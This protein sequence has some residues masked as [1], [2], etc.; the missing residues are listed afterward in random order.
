MPDRRTPPAVC[1][2]APMTMPREIVEHLDNG[3]TFHRF[4]GGDQ[5]ICRLTLH[6][7]GG[8]S[9]MGEA[10]AKMLISQISE[11]TTKRS[12]E[13]IAEALD[14]CGV[15]L[16]TQSQAHHSIISLSLLTSHLPGILPLLTDMI[17]A[18]AFP[19]AR[20]EVAR[21]RLISALRIAREDPAA[22]ADIKLQ[23]L[24]WGTENPLA[25]EMTEADIDAVDTD[26][27]HKC[28]IR[29]I[30]PARM[31]AYLSGLLD[32]D[33]VAA[34]RDFLNNIPVLSD[35][36]DAIYYPPK[37]LPG[38]TMVCT[39][40]TNTMQT[41]ISCALPAPGREHP[42]YVPLRLSVMALG[43][44]FGSRLMS[45]I[46]EDKG[47]T[48]G[49]T[50]ALMGSQDGAQVY[51]GTTTDRSA[52]DIV[53]DE[54]HHELADMA[55]NPP[56][57]EELE[58]FR[59]YAMTGLAEQLDNPISIMQYYGSQNIVGTSKDYFE[60]QQSVLSV[61]TPDE[62]SRVSSLY[63]NPSALLISRTS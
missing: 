41:A 12:A 1:P 23:P 38:G 31:H 62:I 14:F 35:G 26:R 30:C 25:H 54:I 50:A 51:I 61:L 16:N 46:R 44:Y 17:T 22:V 49:I 21:Q 32:D 13:E 56:A 52:T 34:V 2:F 9:E 43:G 36:Y 27:L 11:G 58:R 33:C 59:T 10:T 5:P 63:L 37:P 20:L 57:G 18:P 60:R 7:A 29:M 3:L 4:S 47:L 45:S 42:D 19:A 39:D 40:I 28:H 48:Y 8:I 55:I 24:I 6:F 53:I 15:R